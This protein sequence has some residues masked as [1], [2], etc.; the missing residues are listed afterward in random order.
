[1]TDAHN[2]AGGQM[3]SLSDLTK[4]VI[5]LLKPNSKSPL[6][7]PY[8]IR[9]WFRPF[10]VFPD[11]YSQVGLAWE[12]TQIPDRHGRLQ[13]YYSKSGNLRTYHSQLTINQEL[14]YGIVVL[15]TGG[16]PDSYWF[17]Q[18]AIQAMQ[19]VF[20]T[21]LEVVTD[22]NYGGLWS[23]EGDNGPNQIE[24]KVK[25]GVLWVTKWILNGDDYLKIYGHPR[26]S[27]WSTG[28][29]HEF[30]WVLSCIPQIDAF[31]TFLSR[32]GVGRKE[33][34]IG[35]FLYWVTFDPFNSHNAPVDLGFFEGEGR[36]RVFRMPS[37][38]ITLRRDHV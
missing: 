17:T 38:N 9:E 24:I 36:E 28:R 4:T 32:A 23:S 19:P 20:E 27:L 14:G 21:H 18:K 33:D 25:R 37:T 2:P 34:D 5:A 13:H 35:C 30:R 15:M 6:L 29:L 31:L 1:M 26:I 3:S 11:S 7:S 8:S 10:H 22:Q 12:I 16:Y